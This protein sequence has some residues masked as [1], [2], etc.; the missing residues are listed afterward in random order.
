M[1]PAGY[2]LHLTEGGTGALQYISWKH[3]NNS[4]TN[5]Q[6]AEGG[7]GLPHAVSVACGGISSRVNEDRE[8]NVFTG[9]RVIP[10]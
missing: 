2:W 10:E 4:H 6:H 9:E 3:V 5:H 7:G 8:R 1:S